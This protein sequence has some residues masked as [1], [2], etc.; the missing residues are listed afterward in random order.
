MRQQMV[1]A[2][3][4]SGLHEASAAVDLLRDGGRIEVHEHHL[5]C[6]QMLRIYE[7]RA[8]HVSSLQ[9]SHAAR[10]AE[11]TSP[12]AKERSSGACRSLASS[13]FLRKGG[14]SCG[15]TMRNKG[16]SAQ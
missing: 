7:I 5:L 9:G 2:L 1:D 16:K 10:L 12:K 15:A 8:G 11:A 14:L 13:T 6:D 3:I 4:A